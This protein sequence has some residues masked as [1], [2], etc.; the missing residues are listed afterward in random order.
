MAKPRRDGGVIFS[1]LL[2]LMVFE[3]LRG[4]DISLSVTLRWRRR[5]WEQFKTNLN[6]HSSKGVLA[7]KPSRRRYRPVIL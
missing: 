6:V 4:E 5:G 3:E 7:V 2:L 1:D